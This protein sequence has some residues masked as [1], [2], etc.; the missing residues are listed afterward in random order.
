[1]GILGNILMNV[2]DKFSTKT[3]SERKKEIMGMVDDFEYYASQMEKALLKLR[4]NG[5]ESNIFEMQKA[6]EKTA[7]KFALHVMSLEKSQG[8]DAEIEKVIEEKMT[9]AVERYNDAVRKIA[10]GEPL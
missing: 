8:L 6:Y 5:D 1:M 4:L 10:T 7:N 9:P 3:P 2:G